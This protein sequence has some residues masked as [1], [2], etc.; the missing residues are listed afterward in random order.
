ML[1]FV[2]VVVVVV[3]GLVFFGGGVGGGELSQR[4]NSVLCFVTADVTLWQ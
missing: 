4:L 2:A 3:V 1:F